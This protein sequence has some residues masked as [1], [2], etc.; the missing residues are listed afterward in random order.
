MSLIITIPKSAFTQ[1]VPITPG[2]HEFEITSAVAR[3]SKDAESVNYVV[4]LKLKNDPNEREID[5]YFNSKPTAIGMMKGFIAAL[6]NKTV[7][8]VADSITGGEINF[9]LEMA[10]GKN[11]L[12]KVFHDSYQGRIMSKI[13]ADCWAAV[14]KIPF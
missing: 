12:G 13:E 5:H 9:D 10:I 11:I 6:T 3:P 8:E 1:G 14:G 7:Q 4:T 2:W